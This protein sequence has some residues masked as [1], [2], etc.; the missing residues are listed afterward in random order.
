[1]VRL[2]RTPCALLALFMAAAHAKFARVRVYPFT[3][4]D[5]NGAPIAGNFD[6]NMDQCLPLHYGAMSIRLMEVKFGEWSTELK[7][8]PTGCY[9][10]GYTEN[11]CFERYMDVIV[12][13]GDVIGKCITANDPSRPFHSMSYSCIRP[14][15]AP[16][17]DERDLE[18]LSGR[19]YT[20]VEGQ[21]REQTSPARV[22]TR[23]LSPYLNGTAHSVNTTS[24]DNAPAKEVT[25]LMN[26]TS[27]ETVVEEV[28]LSLNKTSPGKAFEKE[29]A[30]PMDK[31][32]TEKVA[33]VATFFVEHMHNQSS[34]QVGE[35]E[36][37]QAVH[38]NET[39]HGKVFDNATSTYT[40]KTS[41][42][43]LDSDSDSDSDSDDEDE[44]D[45]HG[46]RLEKRI[47]WWKG[48][49]RGAWMLHPW[50]GS[51][52]CYMC[53][54]KKDHL[55]H[56]FECRF[57]YKFPIDCGPRPDA[58]VYTK[59]FTVQPIITMVPGPEGSRVVKRSWHKRVLF[60][61]PWYP[62]LTVCGKAHWEYKGQP[63]SEVRLS[64]NKRKMDKCNRNVDAEN[65]AIYG[66]TA[67]VSA[68]TQTVSLVGHTTPRSANEEHVNVYAE[69][70]PV[71]STLKTT[72][73][74]AAAVAAPPPS[75]VTKE[76]DTFTLE[77]TSTSIF[78]YSDA[79]NPA[80]LFTLTVPMPQ[81]TTVA[82]PTLTTLV[83][84]QTSLRPEPETDIMTFI[85]T[86]TR[87]PKSRKY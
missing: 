26:E 14:L 47:D 62:E 36:K 22:V 84:P 34:E 77:R 65:I 69:P 73:T 79:W 56:D 54:S 32:T 59:T 72:V 76:P 10:Y 20:A 48:P 61:N 39:S 82:K 7:K 85:V 31:T 12:D 13:P 27:T 40:N 51:M 55:L 8:G 18:A 64:D 80:S 44:T 1:M 23:G 60:N 53:F 37:S 29:P 68:P 3:S 5:C 71:A 11:G 75:S 49:H 21:A 52:I 86:S 66:T 81:I 6:T 25:P 87:W 33:E 67:T 15:D 41:N 2:Y 35:P 43:E 63:R 42:A 24:T 45:E 78:Q 46:N 9:W 16:P 38:L 74:P 4:D 19:N 30:P 70:T 17:N 83:L 28:T 58:P 50:T 57:G